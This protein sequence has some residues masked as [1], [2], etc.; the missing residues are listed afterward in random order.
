MRYVAIRS[1]VS[2]LV[3]PE[4]SNAERASVEENDLAAVAAF[5]SNNPDSVSTHLDRILRQ[6][7]KLIAGLPIR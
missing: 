1:V 7:Q 6:V 5:D 2:C 4:F 3:D